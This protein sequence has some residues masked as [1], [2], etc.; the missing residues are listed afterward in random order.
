MML[1]NISPVEVETE[2]VDLKTKN[3]H[4]DFYYNLIEE[5]MSFKAA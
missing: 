3:S 5:T 4:A 1:F 2:L